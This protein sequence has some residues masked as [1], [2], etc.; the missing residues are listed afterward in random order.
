MYM[1][2]R[3]FISPALHLLSS[4]SLQIVIGFL[5][6]VV[7]ARLL[8][9]EHFG[10]YAVVFATIGIVR[11]VFTFNTGVYAIRSDS[12]DAV[13]VGEL[14]VLVVVEFIFSAIAT[15]CL[16]LLFS[17][18]GWLLF[19][20]LMASSFQSLVHLKKSIFERQMNY[21]KLSWLEFG[22]MAAA[23]AVGVFLALAGFGV[24]T[25]FIRD[26]LLAAFL[27]LGLMIFAQTGPVEWPKAFRFRIGFYLRQLGAV[28]IDQIVERGLARVT[29][30]CVD[31]FLGAASAGLFFQAE[32]L[33]MIHQQF[34]QP[35][36]SRFS[37]NYF[38][39]SASENRKQF[40]LI[41]AIA[42][43]LVGCLVV[44]AC[45]F[46]LEDLIVLIYGEK[47][48]KTFPIFMCLFGVLIFLPVMELFKSLF[49]SRNDASGLFWLRAP[50]VVAMAGCLSIFIL[51]DAVTASNIGLAVSCSVGAGLIGSIVFVVLRNRY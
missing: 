25:F 27:F 50:A 38:S 45:S 23:H 32:R 22:S 47:W 4:S 9:V 10:I 43:A 35:I 1:V 29:I 44:V 6:N 49:Y 39:R 16:A 26:L 51:K 15:A 40:L 36:L 48:R 42:S 13:Q 46:L 17:L 24:L 12:I 28:Y 33:A 14:Y 8:D 20:A 3:T 41:L 7:L 21:G 31:H 37:M 19:Y 5:S 18:D 2:F 11:A 30:L 34:L